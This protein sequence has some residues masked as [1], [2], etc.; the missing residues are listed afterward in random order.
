[1][2]IDKGNYKLYKGDCLEV[3]DGLIALGVKFD[4][5]IA[6]LPYGTTRAKWDVIIPFEE[7]WD[8]VHKLIKPTTPVILFG[9]EPFSS[10]LRLSNLKEYKYDWKWIKQRGTGHLN[11][12]KQPMRNNEDVMVFY[13]KQPKYN[14]IMLEGKPYTDKRA[15]QS[16][17]KT[18]YNKAK[19]QTYI[20]KS[21]RYPVNTL[22]FD[23]VCVNQLHNTQKPIDLMDYLIKTY[24]NEG[25]IIL[26]FTMGSGSTIVSAIQNNR[27][28]IGIELDD[29]YFDIACKRL[30][31]IS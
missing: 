2:I 25:D 22:Y 9:N 24:T 10:H 20:N 19:R 30:E 28:A 16:I 14:P 26:D 29:K 15:G 31:E 17:D 8:K 6:D 5:I 23:K 12:K 3:M 11:A 13:K 1:M 27:R 7:M 21:T 4:A 18:L